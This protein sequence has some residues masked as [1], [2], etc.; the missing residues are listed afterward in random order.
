M[1]THKKMLF[2]CSKKPFPVQDG[3]AIRTMQMYKM[4]HQ[5]FQ[6]DL[7]Y[8]CDNIS[9]CVNVNNEI[10]EDVTYLGFY[11]PKW[12]S[13]LQAI[14]GL[15][16]NKPLQCAYFFNG[17]MNKYIKENI[18]Q[19]DY[20]FCNNIRTASYLKNCARTFRYI[21]FV[22][23]I[24]MNYSG[25]AEKHSFPYNLIYKLE[26]KRLSKYESEICRNFNKK[27]IISEVDANYIKSH[28]NSASCEI[29]VIPNSVHIPVETVIQNDNY[30]ITF[31]GSMFY[32]PNILAVTTFAKKVFPLILEKF[33]TA[34]F[35][36]VGS[37]PAKKVKNLAS[38]NIVI[39]GFVEDPKISSN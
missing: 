31:V 9:E 21:D 17:N 12:K 35:Y 13:I 30:N 33:P 10:P 7:L 15:V 27:I 11:L 22:D 37:R 4:L 32:E 29:S 39:T 34:K 36:I 23:A 14:L 1:R 24:S 38:D 25:A 26:S 2:I 16:S 8:S 28:S 20:V 18:N 3:G 5:H 19:Y 6:I